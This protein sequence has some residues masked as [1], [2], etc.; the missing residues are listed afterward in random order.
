MYQK[1]WKMNAKPFENTANVSFYYEAEQHK[2]ALMKLQYVLEQNRGAV[3]FT[4][5]FGSGK[6]FVL[7]QLIAASDPAG[8]EF[9][10]L[11]M[12]FENKDEMLLAICTKLG[13]ESLSAAAGEAA[14][15]GAL[16][17]SIE[18]N[19]AAGKVTV[20]IVED[21]HL[22]EDAKQFENLRALLNLEKDGKFMAAVIFSGGPEFKIDIGALPQFADRLALDFDIGRLTEIE[23]KQ[24][25][26]HRLKV[27]GCDRGIFTKH[28]AGMIAKVSEGLPRRINRVC[29]LCLLASYGLEFTKVGPQVVDMVLTDLTDAVDGA[30]EEAAAGEP[31]A[32]AADAVPEEPSGSADGEP[33]A[34][35]A[36]AVPEEPSGSA[37]GEPDAEAADAV[38]EETSAAAGEPPEEASA[39]DADDTDGAVAP[40]D[41]DAAEAGGA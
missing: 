17:A 5:P 35:A 27:A 18:K 26:L 33:D 16:E 13:A 21:A 29:E 37:D 10:K 2:L 23:C 25:I 4:G 1:Y 31:A 19:F 14:L 30:G 34:E 41:N 12:P 36:D 28:A 7:E 15:V 6:T 8:F 9:V 3:R 39:D 20:V 24:Y 11:V 40:T 22:I 32:E 38:P